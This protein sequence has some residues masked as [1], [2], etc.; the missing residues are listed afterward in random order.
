MMSTSF[1]KKHVL[2]LETMPAGVN[3]VLKTKC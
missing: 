2:L 3:K 1:N